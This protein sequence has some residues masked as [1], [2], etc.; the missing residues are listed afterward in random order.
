[1]VSFCTKKTSHDKFPIKTHTFYGQ[2]DGV[3]PLMSG[4]GTC[5]L[6]EVLLPSLLDVKGEVFLVRSPHEAFRT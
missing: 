6:K 3:D 5:C 4:Q 1:M 2:L